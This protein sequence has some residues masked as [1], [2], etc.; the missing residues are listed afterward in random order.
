[1]G[2]WQ[3]KGLRSGINAMLIG[4]YLTTLGQSPEEDQAMLTE[5]GLEGGETPVNM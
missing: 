1:M 4:N 2:Q 3:H 5:L